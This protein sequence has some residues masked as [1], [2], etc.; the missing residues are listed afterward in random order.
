MRSTV[1]LSLITLFM[2]N[3]C[4]PLLVWAESPG[5]MVTKTI[6]Q[7]MQILRDPAYQEPDQVDIRRQKLWEL[8]EPIFSFEEVAKLALGRHWLDLTPSQQ[9]EFTDTFTNILKDVYLK[10]SDAYQNGEI[11][12]IR[13]I[14]KGSRSKVQTNFVNGE[15]KIIVDFSMK[16]IGNTWK[17][18]D[19]TIETISILTNYRTQFNS[20]LA[21]STFEEMMTK[22]REK[23]IEVSN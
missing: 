15:K 22:L 10:K 21:K 6:D 23:E 1:L 14:V 3:L 5:E 12:Y 20:I 18:Y 19:I 7:G 13:E 16:K 4:S 11:I 9:Q 17:I 2:L 8:L